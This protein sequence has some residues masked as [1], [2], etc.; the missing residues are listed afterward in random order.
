MQIGIDTKQRMQ[1]LC[2]F[3]LEFYKVLMG[4]FLIVFIPQS[5][6]EHT[7]ALTENI[8]FNSLYHNL[9]LLCNSIAFCV[10]LSFY[11]IEMKREYW[12]IEYLDVDNN[13]SNN[14]L[15][16]EIENYPTIKSQMI[17][18]N[19]HYY[20]VTIASLIIVIANYIGL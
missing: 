4:T 17:T 10:I 6:G 20:N 2:L 12:C 11:I 14:N 7:C 18:L 1:S 16:E 15:D 5:C 19:K 3:F 9:I 8:F 13:K